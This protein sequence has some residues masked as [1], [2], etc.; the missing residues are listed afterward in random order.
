MRL[1]LASSIIVIICNKITNLINLEKGIKVS[2][3]Y[4]STDVDD[5]SSMETTT[6]VA[7]EEVYDYPYPDDSDAEYKK[8]CQDK[9]STYL[10]LC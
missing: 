4:I 8:R 10:T 5:V 3:V 1:Q 9:F 2:T 6:P 7:N